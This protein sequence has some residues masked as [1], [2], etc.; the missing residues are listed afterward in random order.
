M[1]NLFA[2]ILF[3]GTVVCFSGANAADGC[4]PGCYATPSG[5]CVVDGWGTA[6]VRNECPAGAKPRP[7]CPPVRGYADYV[8]NRR[9]G[10]CFP[11]S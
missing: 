7:P 10:A 8:W 6:H 5:G 11:R 4:G 9:L 2:A 3:T 1:R